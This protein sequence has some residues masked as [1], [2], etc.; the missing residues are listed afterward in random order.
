MLKQQAVQTIVNQIQNSVAGGGGEVKFIVNWQ[1]YLVKTPEET[2]KKYMNDYLTKT[3]S[4]KSSKSG[5]S[6]AGCIQGFCF[7]KKTS[8]LD[9]DKTYASEGFFGSHAI[10]SSSGDACSSD[11]QCSG[12]AKCVSCASVGAKCSGN[13]CVKQKGSAGGDGGNYYQQLLE[14][15]KKETIDKKSP[16]VTYPGDPSQM[17]KEGNFKNMSIFLQDGSINDPWSYL[18]NAK[19]EYQNKLEEE[20]TIAQTKSIAYE[21]FIGTGEGKYGNGFIK[22]PGSLTKDIV[23]NAQDLGNKVLASATH[24]EEMITAFISQMIT[25]AIDQGIGNVQNQINKLSENVSNKSKEASSGNV[26][27]FGPGSQYG[28]PSAS[29]DCV[30]KKDGDSCTLT[31]PYNGRTTGKCKSGL[32]RP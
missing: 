21:G 22:T 6:P 2:T 31:K 4:G 16:T 28:N 27:Q 17:F 29:E 30:G 11:S 19:E 14:L 3:I 15:A 1:D 32:C 9:S 24:P 20:K 26:S 13:M 18:A 25:K 10:A 5:Y 23:A 8:S 12:G 7:D